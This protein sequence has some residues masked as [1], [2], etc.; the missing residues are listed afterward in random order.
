MKTIPTDLAQEN[1]RL[2]MQLDASCS[3]EE[4]RQVRAERDKLRDALRTLLTVEESW[5]DLN[6]FS[7][8]GDLEA[9]MDAARAALKPRA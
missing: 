2:Q 5:C 9:A 3:A 1:T 7:S 6:Q 4:L 8:R